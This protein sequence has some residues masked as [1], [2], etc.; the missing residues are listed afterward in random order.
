MLLAIVGLG[1]PIGSPSL[2]ERGTAVGRA[3]LGRPVAF[4]GRAATFLGLL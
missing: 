4:F 1:L 2:G 3:C